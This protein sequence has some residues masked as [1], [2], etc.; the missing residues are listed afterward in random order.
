MSDSESNLARIFL[1]LWLDATSRALPRD[2]DL[3]KE[4]C[5]KFFI[6]GL[7]GEC[8]PPEYACPTCGRLKIN[9]EWKTAEIGMGVAPC[10][11]CWV[12]APGEPL[13]MCSYCGLRKLDTQRP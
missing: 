10:F 1:D 3:T 2:Y 12:K 6:A 4:L 9:P 11:H 13:W 7:N 8:V 5:L